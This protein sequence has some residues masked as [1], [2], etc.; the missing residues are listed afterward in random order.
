MGIPAAS[1]ANCV[2]QHQYQHQ[3]VVVVVMMVVALL[4][5][6]IHVE[7]WLDPASWSWPIRR[8]WGHH[9]AV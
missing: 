2:Q 1:K 6:I 9:Q 4:L 8:G 5:A 7:L 3:Q